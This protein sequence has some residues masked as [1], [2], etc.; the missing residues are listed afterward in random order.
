[1]PT[2]TTT[3]PQPAPVAGPVWQIDRAT[4]QER[5]ERKAADSLGKKF[6]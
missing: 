6:I 1:M 4:E 2:T 5:F 3:H